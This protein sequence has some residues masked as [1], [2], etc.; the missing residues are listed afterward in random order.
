MKRRA[1]SDDMFEVPA[2]SFVL[3]DT[4]GE[5]Y[6]CNLRG[7]CVWSVGLATRPNLSKEVST[8]AYSLTTPSGEQHRFSGIVEA[9]RWATST[10]LEE[11]DI[12]SET[13]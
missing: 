6:F 4:V 2:P 1:C 10:A 13:A 5:M 7:F 11:K 12:A 8:D 9:A 3:K